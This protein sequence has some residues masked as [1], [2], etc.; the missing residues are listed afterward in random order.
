MAQTNLGNAYITVVP[1][2]KG[3][4]ATI[5]SELSSAAKTATSS[6]SS[7]LASS[8]KTA[9]KTGGQGYAAAFASSLTGLNTS[10]SKQLTARFASSAGRSAATN[11][12]SGFQGSIQ[13][14]TRNIQTQMNNLKGSFKKWGKTDASQYRTSFQGNIGVIAGITGGLTATALSTF[15]SAISGAVSRYDI[16]QNFPSTME[17]IGF[18]A[19]D[20]SEAI[21]MMS[22]HLEGLPTSLDSVVTNVRM[23]AAATG[24][25]D[26]ST[27]VVLGFN[28]ALVASG[29]STDVAD[30]A[31]Q[32]FVQILSAGKVDADA[33]YSIMTAIPGQMSQVAESMLG[34]GAST[35]DLYGALQS[36]EVSLDDFMQAIVTLDTEGGDGFASFAEQA[37]T[38][39]GGVET[40]W[41]NFKTAITR[42]ITDIITA[43]GGE[44]ISSAMESI[45][46]SI[47]SALSGLANVISFV[48]DAPLLQAA[49]V[50][51]VAAF[52]T[53]KTTMLIV[54]TVQA[55]FNLL[56]MSNPIVLVTTL[57]I[58]L[59]AA[60]VYFFTQTQLG[61]QIWSAFST[62]ISTG[63]QALQ[64]IWNTIWTAI[65]TVFSTVWN[66]I[67]TVFSTVW[68]AISS[69]ISSTL[70]WISETW[71]TVWNTVLS[72]AR[73]IWNWIKETII[74]PVQDIWTK[75]KT[76]LTNIKT[77]W[78]EIWTNVKTT[79]ANIW[80]NIKKSIQDAIDN[81]K[82]KITGIKDDIV[83]FFSDAKDWLFD[84]G[85]NLLQGVWDGIKGAKDWLIEQCGKIKDWVV[86][87]VK[88]F[89][90]IGSPSKVMR[91]EIGKWLPEGIAVGIE[92]NADAV[93][94]AIERIGDDITAIKLPSPELVITPT[95]GSVNAHT[96][97]ARVPTITT[98]A[99]NGSGNTY[100]VYLDGDLLNVDSR[101]E[102]A[103]AQLV[104]G[105]Q[106]TRRMGVA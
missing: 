50:G 29:A 44:S 55:A 69:G 49:I 106:A 100:N 30:A 27:D 40:S 91:D 63:I 72:V 89:F 20:A 56:M 62:L 86:D 26:L 6:L 52:V 98:P 19:E 46:S 79:A 93:D 54:N 77:K 82:K 2:M 11:Y 33:W 43:L 45:G 97:S 99:A 16:I 59:V 101:V 31:M 75:I 37:K 7:T 42:G 34:A 83:D 80:K 104:A 15:T 38:A 36:G 53:Y 68:N 10:V 84:A 71:S 103:L 14:L 17:A 61:Q 65:S 4:A 92:A 57:I 95:L 96:V 8:M 3:V 88:G 94:Q 5:S 90:G 64:A 39:S 76:T 74:Q 13:G 67:S 73:T 35:D 21:A 102:S 32:Q 24:D 66:A 9:G 105:V 28:D 23:V 81:V 58:A 78:D 1:T 22:S 47:E 12:K 85:E 18:T 60:L 87:G 48:K 25:L 70:S 51:I 41:E